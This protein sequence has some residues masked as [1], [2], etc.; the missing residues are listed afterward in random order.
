MVFLSA[1]WGGSALA[2]DRIRRCSRRGAITLMSNGSFQLHELDAHMLPLQH[3]HYIF[4][5]AP[6]HANPRRAPLCLRVTARHPDHSRP[7]PILL[8]PLI[9]PLPGAF[10]SRALRCALTPPLANSPTPTSRHSHSHSLTRLSEMV[11]M[12]FQ[13]ETG[14]C[15]MERG[16]RESHSNV[17]LSVIHHMHWH[18][19][20]AEF[21]RPGGRQSQAHFLPRPGGRLLTEQTE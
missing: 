20:C 3:H 17:A 7:L 10:P 2:G 11:S 5:P 21:S 4:A 18:F 13:N 15:P 6:Y 12:H 16:E 9:L 14:E 19:G 8:L 1:E